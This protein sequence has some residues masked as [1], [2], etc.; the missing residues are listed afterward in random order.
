MS[1]A[2]H[3]EHSEE[4]SP[5]SPTAPFL[6]P[7]DEHSDPRSPHLDTSRQRMLALLRRHIR[8]ERV[9]AA[10]ASVRRE[11]FVPPAVREQAYDDQALPIGAAQTISQPLMVALM[12]QAAEV[13]PGDRALE[14]GTG[15]GYQAAVLSHLA[16]DVTTVER[17]PELHLAAQAVLRQLD[18]ANVHMH[19]AQ[20]MLGWP[21]AA[22]YDAIIVAA[23]APHIPRMLIDQLAP[24]GRLVVPVGDR[25]AQQLLRV[26][27]TAHG[28]TIERLGPCAFVPLINADAW[29]AAG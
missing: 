28:V 13:Q 17:V 21:A 14:V 5:V 20:D 7:I 1:N 4:P 27:R 26:R 8:S 15:S 16:A 25:V 11:V 22:P 3:S 23:G 9:I 29:P 10:M 12:V 19:A 24:G 18:C 2:R 6:D